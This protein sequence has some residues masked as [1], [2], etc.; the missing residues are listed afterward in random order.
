MGRHEGGTG[1]DA[2]GQ[3]AISVGTGSAMSRVRV[4]GTFAVLIGGRDVTPTGHPAEVIKI[5][6]AHGEPL[7]VEQV[8][9]V[10]WPDAPAGKGRERMRNVLVR[11]RGTCGRTVERN[12]PTLRMAAHVQTDHAAYM[13]A[14]ATAI[15]LLLARDPS[16]I[17]AGRRALSLHHGDLLPGDRYADWTALP[18]ER[19]RRQLLSLLDLL[20]RAA[21]AVGDTDDAIRL[22]ARALDIDRYDEARYLQSARLLFDDDRAAAATQILRRGQAVRRELGLGPCAGLTAL[23]LAMTGT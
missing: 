17:D 15:D 1:G 4:L 18:R 12:G 5:L 7:H 14:A 8:A 19:L 3:H 20:A 11:L 16:A 13:R 9:G 21:A 10:L 22:L 23:Q 6:A 2:R